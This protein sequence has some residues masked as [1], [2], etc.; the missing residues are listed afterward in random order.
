MSRFV[1]GNIVID[2]SVFLYFVHLQEG[3]PFI[4]QRPNYKGSFVKVILQFIGYTGCLKKLLHY[5]V[6]YI[7]KT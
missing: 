3:S 1:L 2:A 5:D 4:Q 6:K 7:R